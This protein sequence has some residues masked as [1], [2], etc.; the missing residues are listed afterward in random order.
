MYI[1]RS[2]SK[3]GC[4]DTHFCRKCAISERKR[5]FS[6]LLLYLRFVVSGACSVC[7]G[8]VG[9]EPGLYSSPVGEQLVCLT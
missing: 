9:L 1:S 8:N 2:F 4:K 7:C 5:L 6:R 3:I